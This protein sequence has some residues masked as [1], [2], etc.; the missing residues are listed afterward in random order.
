MERNFQDRCCG[1]LFTAG[2]AQA[3]PGF[4]K[5]EGKVDEIIGLLNASTLRIVAIETAL[6]DMQV[7][8]DHSMQFFESRLSSID[9]K[10]DLPMA[11]KLHPDG[12]GK[13]AVLK[14]MFEKTSKKIEK[15]STEAQSQTTKD[16]GHTQCQTEVLDVAEAAAQTLEQA[17]AH[18][19][20]VL[21]DFASA[22]VQTVALTAEN[23]T[24]THAPQ[25][26]LTITTGDAS[27]S[28]RIESRASASD[29][30]NVGAPD[31]TG[32]V[33]C[34]S[35][36]DIIISDAVDRCRQGTSDAVPEFI[37]DFFVH[38]EKPGWSSTGEGDVTH[39]TPYIPIGATK[40]ESFLE[41]SGIHGS[42]PQLAPFCN[43]PFVL[44][45]DIRQKLLLSFI[46]RIPRRYIGSLDRDL[47]EYAGMASSHTDWD[48]WDWSE[49][50]QWR[51]RW[52]QR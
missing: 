29:A 50:Q 7:A 5:L 40:L 33:D 36:I 19:Q 12:D 51:K 52:A 10:L 24:Q 26:P 35:E 23:L 44:P 43:L 1:L 16:Q 31:R 46:R 45:N 8:F 32:A 2:I 15:I 49:R 27:T 34:L 14:T 3:M 37:L 20:T 28:T 42:C 30:G 41:R 17:S 48:D 6:C 38:I 18:C 4:G 47:Q 21:A 11:P 9:T 25:S 22:A 39:P 13:V